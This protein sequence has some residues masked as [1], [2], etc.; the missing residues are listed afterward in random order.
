MDFGEKNTVKVDFSLMETLVR[1]SEKL[2]AIKRLV[3]NSDYVPVKDLR[4]VLGIEKK[5]GEKS[6]I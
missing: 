5:E 2:G 6:G 3:E 4:A 1:D